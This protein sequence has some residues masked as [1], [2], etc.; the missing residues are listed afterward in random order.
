MKFISP[1]VDYAFKKIFGSEQS[2]DILI[3]FLNAIIYGE[4]K[5]I[6]SLT[7]ANPYNPGQLISLKE[8]YL[9]IKAVLSDSSIVVIKM[10]IAP[11]A[12]FNKRVV[13]NLAKAYSNQLGTGEDYPILNPVI[14]VTVTDFILLKKYDE[15]ISQFVFQEKTKKIELFDNELQLIF[16]E[17]PKFNKALSELNSLTDKWIYFLKEAASLDSIPESLGEV[18]EIELALN[19]ANQA[20]MTVE[21]LE[22]VDR[23]GIMLQDEKGRIAYAKEEGKEE[24]RE[25]GRLTEAIALVMRLLKKRFGEIPLL[26]SS[27]IESLALDDLE[28]LTEDIFDLNSLQDLEKW[29]EALIEYK[30]NLILR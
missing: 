4:E 12:S 24:G 14:A 22:F 18:S 20:N 11:M 10:Q 9:D 29:L 21:E 3:S 26:I 8:S 19:L 27:Q 5:K 28:R 30:T 2:K 16:V 23:R 1:K 6:Q 17:L 7:I 13:Y 25:E 15:V